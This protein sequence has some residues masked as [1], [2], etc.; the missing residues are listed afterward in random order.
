MNVKRAPAGALFRLP[1]VVRYGYGVVVVVVA[2]VVLVVVVVPDGLRTA[3][4][5]A[6]TAYHLAPNAELPSPRV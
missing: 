4:P 1:G 2:V 6:E 5:A 3:L